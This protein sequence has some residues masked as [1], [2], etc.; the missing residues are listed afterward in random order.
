MNR[1]LSD[2]TTLLKL[3]ISS[4]IISIIFT[5]CKEEASIIEQ[6][7]S[8]TEINWR[9]THKLADFFSDASD[10]IIEDTVI[11]KLT[12]AATSSTNNIEN[13]LFLQEGSNAISIALEGAEISSQY[14][15][16][17]ELFLLATGLYLDVNKKMLFLSSQGEAIKLDSLNNKTEL[18]ESGRTIYFDIITDLQDLDESFHKK[19]V[20]IYSIQFDESLIGS[21]VSENENIILSDEEGNNVSLRILAQ[22]DFSDFQ[23]PYESGSVEGILLVENDNFII[24]PDER[25]ALSFDRGRHSMFSKEAFELNGKSIPYQIM[26]PKNYDSNRSYPLVLFLH[27][28][29]E[30][31]TNNTSQMTYGTQVF[32]NQAARENY[33]A[34]VIFPQCPPDSRWSRRIKENINGVEVFTFPVEAEPNESMNMILELTRSYINSGK[35]DAN[36]IY[37]MGLSMGGIGTLEYLYYASDIPAAAIAI[38][39]G[40]DPNLVANYG[41][42]ISIRIYHG[43]NDG[44][45][46]PKYSR[47]LIAA[48]DELPNE[49]AEYFEAVGK[50][51]E[52]NYIL[53]ES[54]SIL[55]WMWSKKKQ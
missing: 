4:I 48:L 21:K 11:F 39:G 13:E 1:T 44:V 6:K 25:E 30:R 47:D 49:D 20:K 5:S 8:P 18:I 43:S 15:K 37:V 27:G 19:R 46:P 26:L 9:Q 16:G 23:I 55:S 50:G 33:P 10:G 51:H 36:Q 54:D 40:H 52:W 29:G 42:D 53:N 34:I 7:I 24:M 35:A 17:T 45:V 38:A 31:G 28:S 3:L 2:N 14:E 12:V 22:A 41:N 32:N